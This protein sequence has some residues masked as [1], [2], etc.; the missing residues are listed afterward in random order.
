MPLYGGVHKL[1]RGGGG[2]RCLNALP[3]FRLE[4]NEKGAFP[5]VGNASFFLNR[6]FQVRK[7]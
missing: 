7:A 3:L 2:G 5:G 1:H 4:N 6:D